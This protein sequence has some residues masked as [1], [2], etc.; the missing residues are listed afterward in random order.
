MAF[1]GLEG[2]D[3]GERRTYGEDYGSHVVVETGC[4]DGFLVRFGCA[5]FLGEN[6]AS[7]DPDGVGAEHQ[8]GC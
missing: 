5:G 2:G 3:E 6:E 1:S 4:S 8:C 7:A